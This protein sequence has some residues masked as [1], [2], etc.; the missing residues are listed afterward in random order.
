MNAPRK[1]VIAEGNKIAQGKE[2]FNFDLKR[3]LNDVSY[4]T[5]NNI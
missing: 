3:Q 5:L 2:D 1:N 4:R